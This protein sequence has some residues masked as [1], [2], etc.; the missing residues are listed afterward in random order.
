MFIKGAPGGVLECC[1]YI[2]N[3]S[4][5][6]IMTEKW[7][8]KIMDHTIEYGTGRDT[9]R[10]LA[11]ATC[12]SPFN[13]NNWDINNATQFAQYKVN[14]TFVRIAGMLDPPRIEVAPVL[15]LCKH[16]GIHV[17]MI[18]GDNKN[19]A[20][21]ICRRIGI[22]T[23]GERTEGKAFSGREFDDLSPVEQKQG[24]KVARMFARVE[25]FHKSK[26]VG[27]LHGMD[28]ITAMTGD[29]CQ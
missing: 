2:R 26:I 17:I 23:E 22:F 3:G 7:R 8:T 9:L 20:K 28:E 27:Y 10:C 12:H 21:A 11:L 25:P 5:K 4:E 14:L 13:P 6:I 19:T 24:T 1:T 15:I 16:A 29:G 18:T